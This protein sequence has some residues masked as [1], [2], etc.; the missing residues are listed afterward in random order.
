VALSAIGN[1]AFQEADIIGITRAVTKHNTLV[2]SADEIPAAI[3]E[4]F[5]IATS[6]KPGPVLIDI[7]KDVQRQL[8]AARP[9]ASVS[10]RSYNPGAVIAPEALAALAEAI[11]RSERPVL[12]V[13][14][15]A[16]SA[17]ASG[18]LTALARKANIPV[19]TTLMGLGAFPENDPLALR[20]LGMHGAAVAN[21]AVSACDLLISLGARFDDRV[22]G[23]IA[24]FAPRAKI[25]HIDIDP[26][27]IGKSV[28]VDFPIRGDAREAAEGLLPLVRPAAHAAW[29]AELD[30]I[31]QRYPLKYNHSDT[32]LQP[33]FVLEEIDRLRKGQGIIVTDVGQH[34]MWATQFIR[35]V[36]PWASAF[37]QQS[38]PSS[39]G[40]ANWS[41]RSAAT[42]ASR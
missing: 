41:W 11:N 28:R 34:Q 25:A 39:P 40:R 15:G 42:A 13:G 30:A 24:E 29:L 20:M 23:K 37:R 1:D 32:V 36:Q 3:A 22:T 38:A 33:M 7:P 26:S 31:K 27:A 17:N 19:T 8:T 10:L 5:Y 4:A 21:L 14:G 16:I 6:G 2:R 35:H 12:Y 18:P 9:P